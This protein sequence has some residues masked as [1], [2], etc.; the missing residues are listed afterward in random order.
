MRTASTRSK[1]VLPKKERARRKPPLHVP[2][3]R[4]CII[5]RASLRAIPGTKMPPR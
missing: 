3:A 4:G 5:F 2:I 1:M